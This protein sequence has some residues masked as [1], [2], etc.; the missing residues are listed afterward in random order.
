MRAMSFR[1]RVAGVCLSGTDGD[2]FPGELVA[3]AKIEWQPIDTEECRSRK[4][5]PAKPLW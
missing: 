5:A 4:R 2:G 1:S 3:R